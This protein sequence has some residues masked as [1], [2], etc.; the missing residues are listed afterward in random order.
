MIIITAAL[1]Q[2]L[3]QALRLREVQMLRP[4]LQPL[5]RLL[6]ELLIMYG[7]VRYVQA[8][9]KAVGAPLFHLQLHRPTIIFAAL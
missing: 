7:Y 6:Q 5:G 3:L 9:I 2:T 4:Q 1:L 8:L